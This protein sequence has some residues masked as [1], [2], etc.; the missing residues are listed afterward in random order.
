MKQPETKYARSGDVSI[1]YQVVGEGPL[2]L[3]CVPGWVSHLEYSWEEPS[4]AR[5]Y[6]RLA[7]FSRLILFDK[8]GTGLSDR[9]TQFPTLEQRM[10]DVRAVMDAAGSQRAAL[11]GISEGGSMCILFA[12]TFP[13]RT[14]AMIGVGI[15]AKR[16]WSPDYPW[17]PTP[18]Q[19]QEFFDSILHSWG[20]VVDLQALAPSRAN[21]PHFREWWSSFLRRS[22]SPGAALELARW[23]TDI[24]VRHVLPAIRVPA[25]IL[26]RRDD[27][28]ASVEEGRYIASH[29]PGARFVE[30]AGGDHIPWTGDSDALLDEIE[31]FLTGVRPAAYS[32]RLLATV[33]FT[34]IVDSTRLLSDIGDQQWR[35]LLDAHDAMVQNQVAQFRGR[36]VNSTG[37]GFL[38]IFDGPARAIRCACALRE[39]VQGLG[40]R[41]R[42]GLHTGE[43][44][45]RDSEI[46][47]IA[48]HIAARVLSKAADGEVWVSRTVKDLVSGSGIQFL[49]QGNFSLK[50]IPEQWNLFSVV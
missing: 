46:G 17:A 34:D 26:H 5:F 20:G 38:A 21:D 2:D 23:N 15:F 39:G 48:V 47:G 40:I 12:A 41:I 49:E 35:A 6:R 10:D 16:I 42:A 14:V 7:S 8:R 43:V 9:V 19:R 33:L 44:E 28:D 50:G 11:M 36:I 4:L 22:A 25:L 29:I 45:L 18:E 30:L 1:A 32:D 13:A 24:D 37:D 27:Q 31:A 3:V